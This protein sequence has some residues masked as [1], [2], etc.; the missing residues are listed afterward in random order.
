MNSES[1][2]REQIR[3]I[4]V[5]FDAENLDIYDNVSSD[6]SII[7]SRSSRNSSR[8]SKYWSL[9]RTEDI[10][11][12]IKRDLNE[13]ELRKDNV[14]ADEQTKSQGQKNND[15]NEEIPGIWPL[16]REALYKR[17]FNSSVNGIPLAYK[18]DKF[19]V[20]IFWIVLF[21]IGFGA[22]VYCNFKFV[23]TAKTHKLL[24]LTFN[25]TIKLTEV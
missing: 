13:I 7:S 8:S 3:D 2:D 23:I 14:L 9:S 22:C 11:D 24:S 1:L 15:L 16:Y 17:C 18:T 25:F 10:G 21:M 19:Y 12:G 6:T 4:R 5:T 20:Y